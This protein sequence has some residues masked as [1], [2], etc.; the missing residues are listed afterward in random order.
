MKT[1]YLYLFAFAF[2]LGIAAFQSLH[3]LDS[4]QESTKAPSSHTTYAQANGTTSPMSRPQPVKGEA[5]QSQDRRQEQSQMRDNNANP[6]N[7]GSSDQRARVGETAPDF[8]LPNSQGRQ[9][10][11]SDYRDK[12]VVL[13]WVNFECPFVKKF[14]D[15]DNM[16]KLQKEATDKGAVWLSI[17]S[18]A[19]GTQGHYDARNANEQRLKHNSNATEYL[20]DEDGSVGRLYG[21]KTT[22]HMFVISPEGRVIY[23]GAIDDK[24]S[25]SSADIARA[26]NYVRQALEE[27]MGGRAVTTASTQPYGCSVKYGRK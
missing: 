17:C 22:P 16:Q 15:S 3:A 8:T 4:S 27:A 19:P 26:R 25:T 11:L 6:D 7:R 13:E 14:Y 21:A 9:V 23:S 1:K 20:L 2:A 5:E 12:Y 24:P 10:S 18:S